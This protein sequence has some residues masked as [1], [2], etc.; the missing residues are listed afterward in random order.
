MLSLVALRAS[1]LSIA[2]EPS[3][4]S[5][6]SLSHS[7][8]R[9]RASRWPQVQR[10][11]SLIRCLRQYHRPRLQDGLCCIRRAFDPNGPLNSSSPLRSAFLSA[12]LSAARRSR[13]HSDIVRWSLLI[14][15]VPRFANVEFQLQLQL[16]LQLSGLPHMRPPS[17]PIVAYFV[18]VSSLCTRRILALRSSHRLQEGVLWLKLPASSCSRIHDGRT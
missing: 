10:C 8:L 13:P 16:P 12:F 4:F 15:P 5:S 6:L 1:H 7:S 18:A 17:S 9:S 14:L 3:I 11:S 2:L